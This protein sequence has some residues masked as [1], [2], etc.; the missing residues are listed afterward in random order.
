MKS[1]YS[2]GGGCSNSRFTL[3]DD[4]T[5]CKV[6]S[7]DEIVFNDEGS[8]FSVKDESILITGFICK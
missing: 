7:H 5:I 3:K 4:D 1:S 6:G 8:L 2:R